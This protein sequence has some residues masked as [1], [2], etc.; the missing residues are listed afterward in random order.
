MPSSQWAFAIKSGNP[1]ALSTG[2]YSYIW[3]Y[4]A[5]KYINMYI[6]M[7]IFIHT[8]C[9]KSICKY[10]YITYTLYIDMY[11]CIEDLKSFWGGYGWIHI[12]IYTH[13][14]KNLLFI[15]RV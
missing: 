2:M 3:A 15:D 7:F 9:M 10:I 14:H 12:C 4:T 8:R 1:V 6:Y 5:Y 11:M 13:P